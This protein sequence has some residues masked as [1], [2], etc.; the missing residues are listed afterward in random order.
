MDLTYAYANARIKGMKSKLFTESKFRELLEVPSIAELIE[1][2]EETEYR[3]AFVASSTKFEGMELI[4]HALKTDL[5]H[6]LA[7]IMKFTPKKGERMLDVMLQEYEVQNLATVLAV[8]DTG[9]S[10]QETD[11]VI[12]NAESKRNLDSLMEKESVGAVIRALQNSEFG[13]SLQQ[14]ALAY[15][16]TRDFR[17]YIRALNAYRFH[18]LLNLAEKQKAPFVADL[19]RMRI[20]LMDLMILLRVKRMD[21]KRDCSEFF[22]RKHHLLINDL[23]KL[24]D[25]DKILDRVAKEYP[26]AVDA[27]AEV[28]SNGSLVP[29][30]IALERR[31]Y[32]YVMRK[33]RLSVL[34][35]S[36]IMSYLYLKQ[37]EIGAIR[38][39]AYAK[40]FKFTEELKSMLFRFSA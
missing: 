3:D 37:L 34:D 29:L 26:K 25:F 8:K 9:A 24:Q 15:D 19:V 5:E 14:Q 30:E 2:L 38:K 28:R 17:L 1:L 35:F 10:I 13:K 21:P 27:V 20:A 16:K 4:A 12:L 39:I 23:N 6:T 31:F 32:G 18:Q 36:T 11:L 40:Q 22:V 33:L 7:K